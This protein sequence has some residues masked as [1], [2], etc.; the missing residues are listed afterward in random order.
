MRLLDG[1]SMLLLN[2]ILI[3]SLWCAF[4]GVLDFMVGVFDFEK[5]VI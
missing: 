3:D 1:Y 2:W 5:F 4:I